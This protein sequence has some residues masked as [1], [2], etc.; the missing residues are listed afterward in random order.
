MKKTKSKPKTRELAV[1]KTPIARYEP[2]P[3]PP[4]YDRHDGAP[5]LDPQTRHTLLELSDSVKQF[6]NLESR[7]AELSTDVRIAENRVSETPDAW[8]HHLQFSLTTLQKEFKDRIP[9]LERQYANM[10]LLLSRM[11]RLEAKINELEASLKK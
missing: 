10:E 7:I 5:G 1:R 2:P 4:R 3:P 6:K 11:D 9:V 8:W